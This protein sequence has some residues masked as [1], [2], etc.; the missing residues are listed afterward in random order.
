MTN[1][2]RSSAP[3]AV[4]RSSGVASGKSQGLHQPADDERVEDAL[5]NVD[6]A[7]RGEKMED[8]LRG[9]RSKGV[10]DA[11]DD[12]IDHNADAPAPPT[13]GRDTQAD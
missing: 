3:P 10:P 1:T 2:G 7:S 9:R 13:K 6:L 5:G 11:F 8:H 4:D 12:S